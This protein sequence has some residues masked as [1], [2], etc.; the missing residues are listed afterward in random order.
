MDAQ[1]YGALALAS[2]PAS[3]PKGYSS[4]RAV[5]SS[6]VDSS[7]YPS[8]Y[9]EPTAPEHVYGGDIP[10][11][12]LQPLTADP[13]NRA[14]GYPLISFGFGGKMCVMFPHTVQRFTSGYDNS[15]LITKKMPNAITI[16]NLGEVL[17]QDPAVQSM[18]DFVGPILL[19]SKMSAKA[20]KKEAL[21][22]MEKRVSEFEAAL[23]KG[24]V[25]NQ[26]GLEN[27][28]V[29]WKLVKTLMEQEGTVGDNDKVDTAIRDMLQ[30]VGSGG[31]DE[32]DSS[33]F[34][35]PAYE[36]TLSTAHGNSN[37]GNA[38]AMMT[39][40]VAG[41]VDYSDSVL[42]KLQKYLIKGDREGAVEYAVQEDMWAHA[43]IIS[44]CVNKELWKKVTNH[45]IEREL[46][47]TPE[48]KQTRVYHN[49]MG[50][51]QALRVLYALFAGSGAASIP[52]GGAP[53]TTLPIGLEKLKQWQ[54]TLLLILAN[55]TPR[56]YEAITALGDLLKAQR[57][58]EAAHICYILSPQSSLHSGIDAPHV[59]LTLLG[60]DGHT[61]SRDLDALYL[62]ELYEF[63]MSNKQTITTSMPFL[64]PY[65][66]AYAWQLVDYG[67][68]GH[69]QRY[70]E[71]IAGAIKANTKRNPWM[72][73]QFVERLE[74]FSEHCEVASGHSLGG[75][76]GSWL[77]T[78]LAKNSLDSLWGSL[79]GRFNKFVSGE[80]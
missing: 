24:P 76:A 18:S 16:K 12:H 35:V 49:V 15:G 14:G 53:N 5:F 79:E 22:Y 32:E 38:T 75:D 30:L 71:A 45:F 40:S 65:K 60:T 7:P 19:D 80:D 69:A 58:I 44:S 8:D 42:D 36:Q 2:A 17:G 9:N 62:S 34:S 70:C 1:E 61:I 6:A 31:G 3:D 57:W 27:K 43:L 33:N 67:L 59:R 52:Y 29:L 26:N 77:K 11:H 74:E 20:K 64:Q 68:T 55:R 23:N 13:L 4:D 73:R 63:A 50:N 56:D 37:G 54:E 25:E 72:H 78:K 51:K 47:A 66:L 41:E 10:Q 48:S 21:V 39:A 46:C 28:I